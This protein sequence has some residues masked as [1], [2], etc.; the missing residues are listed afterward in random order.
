MLLDQSSPVGD[1]ASEAQ[2]W[3]QLDSERCSY[4]T[5]FEAFASFSP[6]SSSST[7]LIDRSKPSRWQKLDLKQAAQI[8]QD[9]SVL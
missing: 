1:S 9:G 3:D 5:G 7:S 6:I 4:S 8:R 2:A